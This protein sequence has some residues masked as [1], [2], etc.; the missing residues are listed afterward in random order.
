MQLEVEIAVREVQASYRAMLAK[1]TATEAAASEVD[2]IERRWRLLPGE[3]RTASLVLEDLLGAQERLTAEEFDF[4][5]AQVT[6]NLA[7]TS[8]KKA[9]GTLLQVENVSVARRDDRGIPSLQL[10]KGH[11]GPASYDVPIR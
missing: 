5:S 11:V 8:L 3:D 4:L 1:R 6:Y 2:Y 7:L 10:H 9:T